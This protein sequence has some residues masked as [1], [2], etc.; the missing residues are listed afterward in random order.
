MDKTP[1]KG[2]AQPG[3]IKS[4]AGGL[5]AVKQTL[6]HLR[7]KKAGAIRGL[8]ILGQMNQKNGFD[9]PGCAW[10]D[11]ADHRSKFE[12]CENGAKAIAEESTRTIAKLSEFS[13]KALTE[14]TDF[15][16]GLLGRIVQPH[17]SKNGS[18]YTSCS[19]EEARNVIQ[20]CKKNLSTPNDAIFYTS[21]RASNEAAFLYQLLGRKLGTN[22]FPD[23]S[24]MCHESSGV[25]MSKTVGVGK[26]TVSLSDFKYAEAIFIFGQNPGTNHPRMLS[27][28]REAAIRGAAIVC[29]NPLKESGL[30]AFKHPQ[31]P[32]DILSKDGVALATEYV[33]LKVGSDIA[34]IKGMLKTLLE[35]QQVEGDIIAQEFISQHTAGLPELEENCS[36][37]SWDQILDATG[38]TKSQIVRCADIYRRSSSSIICWAMGITQHVHGVANVQELVNLALIKGNLGK[39]GAGLCPVRGHSNVQGDRT[40]G[41]NH[42]PSEEFTGR[43]GKAFSFSPPPS[44]GLDVAESIEKMHREDGLLFFALGGNL[45]SA[46]PDSAVVAEA[47]QNCALT[48]H[49]STKP[50]RSHAYPGA[51]SIILPCLGRSELDKQATGDQ[52]VTVENSMSVV[53]R[54]Q[55]RGKPAGENL[56]SEPAIVAL[57][58]DALLDED[59]NDYVANYDRIRDKIEEVVDG[60]ENY[61]Q[62]VRSESGFILPNSARELDFEALGKAQFTVNEIPTFETKEKGLLLMT[63]RSHDQFNTTIY[64]NDDRYRGVYGGRNVVFLNEKDLVKHSLKSGDKI[65]ISSN[66]EKKR[67][68]AGYQVLSYD[69]PEGCA[70]MYFPEGNALVPLSLRDKQ[71][72]TPSSKS[73]VVTIRKHFS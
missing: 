49:V 15:E 12:Y 11:P 60:F 3:R 47:L 57:F 52:F 54:S 17:I 53:H 48:V 16:L 68:I 39:Q 56:R 7:T 34:F 44:K 9:C 46:A 70:A 22:N 58:A 21:G 26:G 30:L 61:N 42:A 19:W 35:W 32:R 40:V 10:P 5:T 55:G 20:E 43:L 45:L 36:K 13:I 29:I 64:G 31:K 25:G 33:Q 65:S 72:G 69:I 18:S 51:V 24:N 73:I 37:T 2:D 38:L 67:C 23:C 8:R 50:N 1:I 63:M 6:S 71:S 14:K 4:V 62:R 41:I 66:Y 27:T 28:L 59:W